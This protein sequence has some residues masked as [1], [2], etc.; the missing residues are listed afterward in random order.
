[1]STTCTNNEI[2]NYD[3]LEATITAR[4]F[5]GLSFLAGY[6][7]SHALTEEPGTG[8]GLASP[9][10]NLNPMADYGPTNFD[11]RHHFS[12]TPSYTIPGRKAPLQLL[13][14]WSVQSA[15]LMT[16]GLPWNASTT[17]NLSGSNEKKDRW[18]FFGNPSDFTQTDTPIPFYGATSRLCLRSV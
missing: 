16:T 7:Y 6:S 2:S 18:D 5:H 15:V 1:M 12:F 3:G 4:N 13:E 10:N 9:Q 14:G 11:Q 17:K 8:Y